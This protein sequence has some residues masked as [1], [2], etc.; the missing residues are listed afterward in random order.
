MVINFLYCIDFPKQS[1]AIE[2]S[3]IVKGWLLCSNI[4][5]SI[6]ISDNP[7][8]NLLFEYGLSRPDVGQYFKWKFPN[9]DY[10]GFTIISENEPIHLKNDFIIDV[11]VEIAEGKSKSLFITINL[12]SSNIQEI[13]V[14]DEHAQSLSN[15]KKTEE[16]LKETLK[17]H[18]W[19]TVR[20]DITNKCN[21][22]CIMCHYKE[23]EIYSQ[24]AKNITSDQLK[25]NLQNIAP[26]VKHIML[27]CG[28]EPLMSKHFFEI[29]GML[30]DNFPHIEI[31]F[32]TNGMLLDSKA[33]KTIIEKNVTHLT[34][35][36]DGA[37]KTT[38]ERIRAGANFEKIISN[39]MALNEL[40]QKHKRNFPLLFM[41]FVLMN[42]NIHEAPA[43]VQLC[44]KLGIEIID[45][46][47]LVGNIYFNEHEEMLIHCK[48]KYN[49]Y[50]QMI[51]D[52]SK[53]FNIKVRLP[54]AFETN[55][56]YTHEVISEI[57][58]SDFNNARPDFQTEEVVNTEEIVI[59]GVNDSD[60]DFLSK[61][62]CLRPFNEIMI[63]DQEKIL[64]CSY[65][66]DAMGYL[67]ENN[68]LFSIFFSEKF[69]KV[70][71]KKMQSRF[72]H[73]CLNCP[74]KANLLPTDIVK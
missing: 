28:F 39:I 30:N 43:F 57:D 5:N 48:E 26:Y 51:I 15:H 25:Q 20:M 59:K 49:Y 41:D 13:E 1:D 29:I 56:L 11:E 22:R 34:L 52:E 46:R 19:I 37:T 60:Y 21:L 7:N 17:K 38:V 40:K 23:K 31:G 6:H 8:R 33:R 66:S 10:C 47:H 58:V 62:S 4:I 64:P 9:N 69:Q 44:V 68:T 42:S 53:K 74:I 55:G 16:K 36:L 45:F 54:D 50:R 14:D 71:Q 35:S 32:C 3:D 12:N 67:D 24:A 73:N 72:D 27:S 63:I 2:K 65:Y 61:A 18:P 70:R